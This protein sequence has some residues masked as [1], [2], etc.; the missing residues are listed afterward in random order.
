M[1]T[2]FTHNRYGDVGEPEITVLS[3]FKS[4]IREI[5]ARILRV[6]CPVLTKESLR[7]DHGS[8]GNFTHTHI[9]KQSPNNFSSFH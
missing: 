5:C 7:L 6:N 2:I 4:L 8:A 3:R 1:E 9:A